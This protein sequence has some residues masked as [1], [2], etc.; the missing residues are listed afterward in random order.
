V[1][2]VAP[3]TGQVP[4][5]VPRDAVVGTAVLRVWPLSRFGPVSAPDPTAGALAGASR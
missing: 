2:L 4:R 5:S 3:V 1:S